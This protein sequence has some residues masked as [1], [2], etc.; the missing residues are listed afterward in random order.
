MLVPPMPTGLRRHAAAVLLLFALGLARWWPQLAWEQ[1][2]YDELDYLHEA[3]LVR[4]GQSPYGE[5]RFLY[6][7]SFAV[8]GAAAL[9][10]L[11]PIELARV[12]RGLDL[13][14][15]VAAAWVAALGTPWRRRWR[16]LAAALVVLLA[17]G[18][19]LAAE[20]GNVS[21]LVVGLSLVGS[22][23]APR[24]PLVAGALLGF[25][26]AIKPLAAAAAVL[27]AAL[28]APTAELR[29]ARRAGWLAL[30]IGGALLLGLG[31]RYLP[32]LLARSQGRPD[33]A[34]NVSLLRVLHCFG[35]E[36]PAPLVF[37]AVAAAAA[38]LCRRRPPDRGRLLLV[39]SSVA[40]LALPV[41]WAHTLLLALPV[42]LAAVAR[43][44]ER[45]RLASSRGRAAVELGAVGCGVVAIQGAAGATVLAGLPLPLQGLWLLLP[46]LAPAALLVYA[47]ATAPALAA[48]EEDGAPAP[49]AA[50]AAAAVADPEASA[51]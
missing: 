30:A 2:H 9:E 38:V 17:P 25:G 14:G 44:I 35:V 29:R 10:L 42:Q 50:A 26:L 36:L 24:R 47:L 32:D 22:W 18:F 6:P 4:Q 8:L 48:S 31:A 46:V 39:A 23:M 1:L 11:P 41:V 16:L 37:A 43:A 28:G 45:R 5:P 15:L 49:V 12:V 27:L 19:G 51:P 40:P 34:G 7:P 13:L 21:P 3:T 33:I 20:Y